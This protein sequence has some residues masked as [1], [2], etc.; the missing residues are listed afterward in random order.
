MKFVVDEQLPQRLATWLTAK[1]YDAIHADDVPHTSGRL[2][3][4]P[5][6]SLQMHTTVL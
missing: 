1:G 2:S 5:F 3:M 6:V 4:L